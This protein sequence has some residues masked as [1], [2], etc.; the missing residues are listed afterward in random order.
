M[1]EPLNVLL[2]SAFTVFILKLLISDSATRVRAHIIA[3]LCPFLLVFKG[4][5]GLFVFCTVQ[6]TSFYRRTFRSSA[7]AATGSGLP[8]LFSSRRWLPWSM[9]AGSCSAWAT[10]CRWSSAASARHARGQRGRGQEPQQGDAFNV[11][12]QSGEPLVIGVMMS[13]RRVGSR[14]ER[15][16]ESSRA[17]PGSHA[18]AGLFR[19]ASCGLDV[20]SPRPW[21]GLGITL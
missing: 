18:D 2:F 9:S 8:P 14:S 20:S 1:T 6:K 16:S 17:K 15:R 21:A 19:S 3:R 10:S 5:T 13:P 7:A 12:Q 11:P 4:E